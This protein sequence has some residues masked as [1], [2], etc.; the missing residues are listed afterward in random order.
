MRD[1]QV[2]LFLLNLVLGRLLDFFEYDRGQK[3]GS[4]VVDHLV[5]FAVREGASEE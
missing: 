1:S 5:F 2:G 4:A 3:R